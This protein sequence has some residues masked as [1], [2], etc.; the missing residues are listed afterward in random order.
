VSEDDA[1]DEPEDPVGMDESYACTQAIR[2]ILPN[3]NAS[4][5]VESLCEVCDQLGQQVEL[6]IKAV[7]PSADVFL[8]QKQTLYSLCKLMG[9]TQPVLLVKLARIALKLISAPL[10]DH[11][12]VGGTAESTVEGHETIK[13]SHALLTTS[14]LLWQLSKDEANDA[15]FKK[16]QAPVALLAVL[17]LALQCMRRSKKKKSRSSSSAPKVNG[18]PFAF[19]VLIF[20]CGTLKNVSNMESNQ[21]MLCQQGAVHCLSNI[22]RNG[23]PGGCWYQHESTKTAQMLVQ[24]TAALRNLCVDKKHWKQFWDAQVVERLCLLVMA[25]ETH[26]ELCLNISRILGKLT[27]NEK[28]RAIIN[29]DKQNFPN[30]LN[31]L[32]PKAQA[33]KRK[34]AKK[35]SKGSSGE[36]GGQIFEM[37]QTNESETKEGEKGEGGEGGD[38]V[39]PSNALVVRVCFVLG[40]MT[41]GNEKNRQLF[42]KNNGT[43]VGIQTLQRHAT[44]YFRLRRKEEEQQLVEDGQGE[45]KEAGEGEG[46]GEQRAEGKAGKKSGK[47]AMRQLLA[48]LKDV[49]DVLIKLIRLLANVA[50]STHSGPLIACA[51]GIDVLTPVLQ[52]AAASTVG[53]GS[54]GWR[55]SAEELMLNCVSLITNMSFYGNPGSGGGD[56]SIWTMKLGVSDALLPILLHENEEAV[57]EAARAFGNLSRDAEV[58]AQMAESRVDE[59]LCVLLDHS[60][61][62]IV[63]TVCGVVMN[64][65]ADEGNKEAII[66]PE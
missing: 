19:D 10:L 12:A 20:V 22:M 24:V 7:E 41:S 29:A 23:A 30:L 63:F 64:I 60:N 1:T 47:G 46:G 25:Y 52:S 58:R 31:L 17:E 53:T 40:N 49:E 65:A 59:A 55:A 28:C 42:E 16:E 14:K 48:R 57:I 61:R 56:G 13:A 50:I 2:A 4:S 39:Y 36:I 27:M 54:R 37:G 8:V 43:E 21:R 33:K 51:E 18:L 62:E 32:R 45:S 9:R 6:L 15:L 11:D 5:D 35:D 38:L 44:E 3:L 66:S 34:D 26:E